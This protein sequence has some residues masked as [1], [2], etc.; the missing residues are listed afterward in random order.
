MTAPVRRKVR[1]VYAN[2]YEAVGAALEAIV[3]SGPNSRDFHPQ[4]I[5]AFI[6]AWREHAGRV[7]R[8]RS[9]R[10]EFLALIDGIDAQE[11]K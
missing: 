9:V 1:E 6:E 2:A 7:E 8:L 10:L 5:D 11:S 3:A 4:G